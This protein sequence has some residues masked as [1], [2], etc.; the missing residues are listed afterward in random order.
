MLRY[1]EQRGAGA[2]AVGGGERGGYHVVFSQ[3]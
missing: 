2:P 3:F 1:A